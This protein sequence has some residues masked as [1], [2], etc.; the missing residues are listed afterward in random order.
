MKET[1]YHTTFIGLALRYHDIYVKYSYIGY[2]YI[3]EVIVIIYE[4]IIIIIYVFI[5]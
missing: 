1:T 3:S 4:N 2:Y 5:Y